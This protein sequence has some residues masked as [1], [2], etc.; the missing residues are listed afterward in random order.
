MLGFMVQ[1][2]NSSNEDDIL[3]I[4]DQD[5][6]NRAPKRGNWNQELHDM[7]PKKG[8][9][10]QEHEDRAPRRYHYFNQESQ[11]VRM[12]VDLPNFNGRMDVENFIDWVQNIEKFLL[13][14]QDPEHK[15]VRLV[16]FKLKSGISTWWDQLQNNR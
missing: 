15:K 12:K 2:S 8:G 3:G 11:E 10:N 16:A 9:W 1:D 4:E 14:C 6:Y 7:A 5:C 13:L